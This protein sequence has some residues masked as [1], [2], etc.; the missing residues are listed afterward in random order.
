M[1]LSLLF[2]RWAYSHVMFATGLQLI[3]LGFV[4][5]CNW[6]FARPAAGLFAT[7]LF[8]DDFLL[9]FQVL[10]SFLIILFLVSFIFFCTR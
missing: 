7:G 8:Y 6:V 9:H 10:F 1:R 3:L 4:S 2:C 5:L